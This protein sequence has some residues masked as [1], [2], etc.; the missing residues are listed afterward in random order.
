MDQSYVNVIKVTPQGRRKMRFSLI[1]WEAIQ[2]D[3]QPEGTHFELAPGEIKESAHT[4]RDPQKL[5]EDQVREF[6][7]TKLAEKLNVDPVD[8]MYDELVK[9][10]M[11]KQENK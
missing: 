10:W 4:A 3:T 1:M 11:E 9:M 8:F 2:R 5:T 6:D 7:K